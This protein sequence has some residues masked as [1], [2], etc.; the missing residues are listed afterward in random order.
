MWKSFSDNLAI[1]LSYIQHNKVVI[2]IYVL[3]LVFFFFFLFG[4]GPSLSSPEQI[5]AFEKAGPNL[6]EEIVIGST[7]KPETRIGP[8]RIVDGDL[9]ELQIPAIVR[10][11][12]S[13]VSDLVQADL[14]TSRS[15]PY[16]C[17]VNDDGNIALPILG[18]MPVTGKTVAEVEAMIVNAYYPKYV[19]NIP[20]VVCQVAKYK[21]ENERVFTVVGLVRKPDTYPYPSDVQYNLTEALGFAGGI[22][23]IA[24]PHYVTIYRQNANGEIISVVFRIDGKS[25]AKAYD[26]VIKPRDVICVDQ[27]IRTRTNEFIAGIFHVGVGAEAYVYR[28]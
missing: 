19:V 2:S 4:C 27:T 3:T 9:L 21:H 14:D 18:E 8:Y 20:M 28:Q 15:R 11:I 5:K 23:M 6:S 1:T 17:R 13:N 25:R 12:S 26:L 7:G 16:L 24:D 10:V 22:N